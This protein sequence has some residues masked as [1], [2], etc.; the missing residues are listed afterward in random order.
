MRWPSWSFP[1]MPTTPFASLRVLRVSRPDARVLWDAL[2]SYPVD[3]LRSWR[4]GQLLLQL[5]RLPLRPLIMRCPRCGGAGDRGLPENDAGCPGDCCRVCDFCLGY[6]WFARSEL[7]LEPTG[8]P[9]PN[10]AT[11]A[12]KKTTAGQRAIEAAVATQRQ[13]RSSAATNPHD[14]MRAHASALPHPEYQWE[15]GRT[16]AAFPLVRPDVSL[17]LAAI[18]TFDVREE[19][20][21][22]HRRLV[23][24]LSR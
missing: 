19:D 5:S 17:V 6:R 4:R 13:M 24:D 23:R 20:R 21:G 18:S 22:R 14:V 9:H 8:D 11:V 15:V 12:F 10:L 3:L 7:R 1:Q 2:Q 16:S